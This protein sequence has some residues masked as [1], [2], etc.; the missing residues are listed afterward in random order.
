MKKYCLPCSLH[1]GVGA[2]IGFLNGAGITYLKISPFVMTLGMAGVVTGAIIV[3]NAW[4]RQRE[5][6][7]DHDPSDRPP[8]IAEVY[9]SRTRS[10]SG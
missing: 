10:S 8:A 1:S 3:I 6:G 5:G 7:A 2:V 4:Q 9:R